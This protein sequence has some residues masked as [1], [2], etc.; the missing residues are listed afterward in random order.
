MLHF[1]SVSVE[2][3]DFDADWLIKSI[4]AE[5]KKVLFE[6]QGKN[7]DLELLID[8]QDN[9]EVFDTLSVGELVHLPEETFLVSKAGPYRPNYECF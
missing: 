1:P 9:P 5:E 3:F 2:E 4:D 8:Y 6:G 7:A